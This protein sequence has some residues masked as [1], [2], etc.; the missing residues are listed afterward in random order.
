VFLEN[1]ANSK[2]L[3]Y[4]LIGDAHKDFLGNVNHFILVYLTFVLIVLILVSLLLL[5]VLVTII[6]L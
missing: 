1:F 6:W 4:N 3:L 5:I 2:L